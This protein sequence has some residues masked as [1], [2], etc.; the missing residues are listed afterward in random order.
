MPGA[1]LTSIDAVQAM[2]AAV[3]SFRQ[4]ATSALEDLDMEI[5]RA[6]EW[7]QHDRRDHWTYEVRRGYERVSEAR[8]QLQQA[9]TFRRI[10]NDDPSCLDEKKALERS[11]RRLETAE[12][13]VAAVRHWSRVIEHA[14]HEY[15]GTRGQVTGWLDA[16]YPK[17]VAVLKRMMAA[18]ERYVSADVPGEIGQELA[19]TFEAAQQPQQ[20]GVPC[21]TGT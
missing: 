12:E 3:E 8:V 16:D 2:S 20:E 19:A 14:V 10:G 11:K 21:D 18:L 7:I 15:R 9:K 1:R 6:V 17:A 4:E 13:K 5:R